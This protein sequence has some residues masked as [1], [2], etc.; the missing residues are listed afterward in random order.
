[1]NVLNRFIEL[2]RVFI[3]GRGLPFLG[4][5][6]SMNAFVPRDRS[7]RPTV[8][9]MI[10]EIVKEACK[11]RSPEENR[12]WI[13]LLGL[14]DKTKELIEND[15]LGNIDKIADG[16]SGQLGKLCEVLEQQNIFSHRE[17]VELIKI[18][19]FAELEPLPAHYY[20]AFLVQEILVNEVITTNYD[21]CLEKA[22]T[23]ASTGS[24]EQGKENSGSESIFD[25]NTYSDHGARRLFPY[26]LAAVLRIYKINGCARQL[27]NDP[28]HADSILLTER[29]LQHMDDRC[30]ARDLIKDRARSRSLVF[31]GFGSEE[32]Q[33]R[34]TVLRL[35][36]EF[37][38]S[39]FYARDPKNAIWMHV[40]DSTPS[41]AQNQIMYG[42]WNHHT[43]GDGT[44]RIEAHTFSG[45]DTFKIYEYLDQVPPDHRDDK[46]SGDL[47]WQTVFQIVFLA[48]IERYTRPPFQGWR[49]L[50]KLDNPSMGVQRQYQ[51]MRWIDPCGI[52]TAVLD[53][54][55]PA[56]SR[57]C[58]KRI[59]AILGYKKRIPRI[60]GDH[61]IE[62]I[63]LSLWLRCL[64]G[65]AITSTE[66]YIPPE[67]LY[68]SLLAH[69]ELILSL[70]ALCCFL[71]ND[72]GEQDG[73][74]FGI[75]YPDNRPQGVPLL[76]LRFF[77]GKI[78]L[79]ASES[80]DGFIDFADNGLGLPEPR[81]YLVAFVDYP[82]SAVFSP[83]MPKKRLFKAFLYTNRLTNRLKVGWMVPVRVEDIIR[84]HLRSQTEND[85]GEDYFMKFVV[86]ITLHISKRPERKH[87]MARLTRIQTAEDN[88]AGEGN[89]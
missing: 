17:I 89:G 79:C 62:G 81:F 11:R 68:R 76:Y 55:V 3:E 88:Q 77:N 69:T 48:L 43:D 74:V 33:V 60:S 16:I 46:L 53:G 52:G 21:C 28:K 86:K 45:N 1:M 36:E 2:A 73:P 75:Q 15:C 44:D 25:L 7:I 56:E 70:L 5:G 19:E 61:K 85:L 41:F 9:W 51:F 72:D 37:S 29:Q 34:F 42:Y 39:D 47:F 38:R 18:R 71:N 80:I 66:S 50:T 84:T 6:I 14:G 49:W 24:A 27:G 23:N 40:F 67:C 4:A 54:E 58:L 78:F 64:E 8:Q 59:N 12:N 22:V 83:E 10:R 57:G 35:L 82:A 32:P 30:W 65:R 20:I 26:N 13:S 87:H 31:S 63:P